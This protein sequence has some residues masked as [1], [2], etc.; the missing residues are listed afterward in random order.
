M[1]STLNN[2]NAFFDKLDRVINNNDHTVFTGNQWVMALMI[3]TG[4]QHRKVK[5]LCQWH[6]LTQQDVLFLL[7]QDCSYI[8]YCPVDKLSKFGWNQIVDK[9]PQIKNH[10]L[11]KLA[12]V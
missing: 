11:Y 12:S 5:R 1:I 2:S 8:E 10:P 7:L 4:H 3:T 9:F 6:L